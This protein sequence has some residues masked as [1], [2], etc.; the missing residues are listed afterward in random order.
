MHRGAR[1][2]GLTVFAASIACIAFGR[3]VG[4]TGRPL[5]PF[6]FPN[7]RAPVTLDVRTYV[8]TSRISSRKQ[9]A[10]KAV[11]RDETESWRR[12]PRRGAAPASHLPGLP[13]LCDYPSQQPLILTG[14]EL[15]YA[16]RV[17]FIPILR[18][19]R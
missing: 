16:K 5:F 8:H 12:K 17:T 18:V 15:H 19:F 3:S 10:V 14:N 11:D 1:C 9:F 4:R 2:I 7:E 6:V 13:I